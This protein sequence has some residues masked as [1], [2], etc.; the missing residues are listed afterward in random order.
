MKE[1]VLQ[2]IHNL[3][4]IKNQLNDLAPIEKDILLQEIRQLYV[5]ILEA[6]TTKTEEAI[7]VITPA[8][9]EPKEEK[10]VEA[11]ESPAEEPAMEFDTKEEEPTPEPEIIAE[12][13]EPAVEPEPEI[14]ELEPIEPEPEPEPVVKEP[15]EA[16]QPEVAATLEP[17]PADIA[18]DLLQF[19][20][21]EMTEEKAVA[22]QPE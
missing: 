2:I 9:E 1:S 4:D 20:P 16:A 15:A 6:E 22:E 5:S 3:T 8:K 21:K 12:E 10:V 7:P 13:P 11:Q 18:D 14:A 19:L 17:E